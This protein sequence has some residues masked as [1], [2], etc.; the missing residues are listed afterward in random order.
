MNKIRVAVLSGGTSNERAVSCRTG[1]SVAHALA[2]THTVHTVHIDAHGAWHHSTPEGS[3]H[4]LAPH[5]LQ[6]LVDIVYIA[7][8]GAFG[9]DGQV[10]ALLDEYC[11]PYTGSNAAASALCMDKARCSDTC[12]AGG[13]PTPRHTVIFRDTAQHATIINTAAQHGFPCVIK[14]NASGSSVGVSI[15]RC[16]EDVLPA[17]EAAWKEDTTALI[18][19][20]IRGREVSCAVLGNAG[21][22]CTPLP[23]IEV[24]P[25]QS[26]FFDYTAKYTA[27]EATETCPAV[28]PK[29]TTQAIQHAAVRA[30][31]LCGCD[32]LT[33]SDFRIAENGTP[34]FM[35]INTV[36]G[37]TP[38]SLCPQEAVAAGMSFEE[39]VSL[40]VRLGVEKYAPEL[41]AAPL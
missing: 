18:Q 32:G 24:T 10:Q 19:D 38:T 15:V 41:S 1:E 22:A 39:F 11:I 20:Y 8:H 37:Q 26:D 16:A 25:L 2:Q 23:V 21:G 17:I 6:H 12:R 28:L 35:E 40:Q 3:T 5:A 13:I 34:C 31:Q 33:R 4:T 7:L 29:E 36:P 9:E 14:P 27:G 30:H